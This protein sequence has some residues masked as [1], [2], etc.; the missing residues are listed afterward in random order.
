MAGTNHIE[1]GTIMGTVGGTLLAVI[2]NI[3]SQD[4]SK[5]VVLGAIGACV[6]FTC[7]MMLK[8]LYRKFIDFIMKKK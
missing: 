5:T 6:S 2:V 8:Y 1:G 7:T 4:I 3:N